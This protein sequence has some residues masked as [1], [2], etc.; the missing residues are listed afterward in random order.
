MAEKISLET[1]LEENM[2]NR[3]ERSLGAT[4]ETRVEGRMGSNLEAS[5]KAD[6][7]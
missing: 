3:E 1:S 2:E 7:G 6:L 4:K 5:Q